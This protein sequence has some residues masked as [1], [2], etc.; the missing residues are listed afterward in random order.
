MRYYDDLVKMLVWVLVRQY[1]KWNSVNKPED[2]SRQQ[3]QQQINFI[4]N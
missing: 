2:D 3:Q 1:T 4:N